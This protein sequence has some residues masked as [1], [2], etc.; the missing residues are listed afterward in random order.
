MLENIQG[1]TLD[2]QELL[3]KIVFQVK[4]LTDKRTNLL[5]A[6]FSKQDLNEIQSTVDKCL[7][8]ILAKQECSRSAMH[9][10]EI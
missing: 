4:L 8:K 3:I 10:L 6:L 2:I 9:Q 7:A 1:K 5:D